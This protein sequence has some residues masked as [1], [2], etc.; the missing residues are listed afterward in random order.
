MVLTNSQKTD[1]LQNA[2]EIGI[3]D[4]TVIQLGNE[5]ITTVANFLNFDEDNIQ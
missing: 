1:F 2:T 3:P 4:K 5:G